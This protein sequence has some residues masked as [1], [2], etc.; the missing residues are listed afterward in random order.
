M[1][2]P[3]FEQAF[4]YGISNPTGA[5]DP[6]GLSA[7]G[8]LGKLCTNIPHPLGKA[9][10]AMILALAAAQASDNALDETKK[11]NGCPTQKCLSV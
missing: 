4:G 11:C 10:G 9:I 1:Y 8:S 6:M 2:L 3:Q 7:V 5:I